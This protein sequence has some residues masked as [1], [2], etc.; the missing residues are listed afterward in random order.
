MHALWALGQLGAAGLRAGFGDDLAWA[1]EEAAPLREQITRIAGERGE[2]GGDWLVGD[3]IAALEEPSPRVRFFAAQS[4]GRL[5]AREAVGP[6]FAL[7]RENDDRDPFLR[8]AA[9]FALYRIGDVDAALA[10]ADDP[11]AAVRLAVLLQLRRAARS[12][13]ARFLGDPDPFLVVEA[14]RA[15][16]D[17]PIPEALASLAALLESRRLPS[18]DDPQS[19]YALHRRVIGAN[20][21]LGDEAS[22]LRLASYT[23]YD[24]VPLEMRRLALETLGEFSEPA[25]RDLAM[26]W[27][28][29]LAPRDPAVV[30]A[31]LDRYG[32]ALVTGDL[33]DRA[34]EIATAYGR[35][36]LPDDELLTRVE[37][38]S[39]EPSHR[40]ASL[41]ALASRS[42]PELDGAIAVAL[43]S[44][45]PQLR[46][47]G[48]R[49][50]A[51]LDREASLSSVLA[52]PKDAPL[53]ERQSGWRTL[54]TIGG[55]EAAAYVASSLDRWADGSLDP[56]VALEVLEAA[57]ALETDG[58][59]ARL[60]QIDA[61]HDRD[62]VRSRAYALA[63]G[64]AGRGKLVFQTRGDCQRC[65]HGPGGDGHGSGVGPDLGGVMSR[66]S[67]EHVLESILEP[68]AEIA[69]GFATVSVVLQDGRVLSGTLARESEI[70]LVIQVGG[71]G[72]SEMSVP[73]SEIRE[74]S[75]A[76]SGMP[77]LGLA[78]SPRELRDLVAYVATL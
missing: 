43:S 13:I 65:H 17:V 72:G 10:R 4:L 66:R 8:H 47:Q 29:P 16:H 22:A 46:A 37:N 61:E 71:E 42:A 15:I 5:A 35:I 26:T 41:T 30:H 55:E 52:I 21:T 53:A 2:A 68:Q 54:V 6:L 9:V 23:L 27:H 76:T 64:D 67:P 39:L 19:S 69:A 73:T 63:G 75:P 18:S 78:L 77:P 11:S 44:D 56:A 50:L 45:S 70:E 62:P 1:A 31:A 38:P 24:E 48:R 40:I 58:L 20:R 32:P 36:P 25:P 51:G 7:V 34:M 33:G 14:A 74:R 3:L 57:R 28:R 60:A 49:L 59:A 12:E